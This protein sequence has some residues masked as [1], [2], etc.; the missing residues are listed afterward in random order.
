MTTC[1]SSTPMM[2]AIAQ[3]AS[4]QVTGISSAQVP[5]RPDWETDKHNDQQDR[6]TSQFPQTCQ[7]SGQHDLQADR[8]K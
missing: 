3:R 4:G 1:T 8:V 2:Y 5:K 6:I 7:E